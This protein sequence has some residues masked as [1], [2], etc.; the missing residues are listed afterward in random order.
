MKAELTNGT[1]IE[2][3]KDCECL[4]HDG[5]HWVHM[6]RLWYERNMALLNGEWSQ[7]KAF[8]LASQELHRLTDKR[9]TMERLGIKRIVPSEAVS[10]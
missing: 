8:A 7:Q 1:T 2:L 5:P 3:V 9:R 6:D 10:E 4:T